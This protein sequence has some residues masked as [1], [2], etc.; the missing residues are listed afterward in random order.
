MNSARGREFKALVAA[1][2]YVRSPAPNCFLNCSRVRLVFGCSHSCCGGITLA[3]VCAVLCVPIISG[4]TE[5]VDLGSQ[6]DPHNGISGAA[7]LS[8]GFG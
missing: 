6:I 3:H 8:L 7:G 4:A 2:F 1:A 5:V